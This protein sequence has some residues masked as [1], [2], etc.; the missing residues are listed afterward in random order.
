MACEVPVVASNVGGLP[1][2]IEHGVTG[3]LHGENDLDAMAASAVALLN[4]DALHERVALAACRRAREH[5]SVERVVPMYEDCYRA[6]LGR[7]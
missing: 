5:F 4:D 7:Q 6:V 3:F 2:V 1:E